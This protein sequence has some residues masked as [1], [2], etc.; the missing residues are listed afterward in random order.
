MKNIDNNNNNNNNN[1]I[2]IYNLFFYQ[3]IGTESLKFSFAIAGI[4]YILKYIKL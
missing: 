3:H 1:N 2:Y 4:K